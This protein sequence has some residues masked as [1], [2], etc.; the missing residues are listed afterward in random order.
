MHV[1]KTLMVFTLIAAIIVSSLTLIQISEYPKLKKFAL[2]LDSFSFNLE[3]FNGKLFIVCLVKRESP[4]IVTYCLNSTDLSLIWKYERSETVYWYWVKTFLGCNGSRLAI[5]YLNKIILLDSSTGKI[6][7]E[8]SEQGVCTY[9]DEQF[10]YLYSDAP[11]AVAIYSMQDLE[12]IS[13]INLNGSLVELASSEDFIAIFEESLNTSAITLE[14]YMKNGSS[15]VR[16]Y[17]VSLPWIYVYKSQIIG[18]YIIVSY[19]S[20]YW[21]ELYIA[22][23]KIETGEIT[24]S[25]QISVGERY[26]ST[27]A[28]EEDYI[29]V[30]TEG[31][32]ILTSSTLLTLYTENFSLLSSITL[33]ESSLNFMGRVGDYV[34]L[35]TYLPYSMGM[36]SYNGKG[37]VVNFKTGKIYEMEAPLA[38]KSNSKAYYISPSKTLKEFRLETFNRIRESHKTIITL[39]VASIVCI[40]VAMLIMLAFKAAKRQGRG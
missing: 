24:Y 34:I 19:H 30:I 14:V 25:K 26:I 33:K 39:S 2:P 3:Y 28:I 20:R 9:A 15:I 13:V 4:R 17:R 36:E 16:R 23:I 29:Y 6:L 40:T 10:L 32:Y 12:L 27:I 1:D 35:S 8:I 22:R 11:P 7:N 38:F 21:P 5:V 18:D 37:Y 31:L